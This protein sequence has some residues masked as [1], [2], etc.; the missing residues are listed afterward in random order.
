MLHSHTPTPYL[1][2]ITTSEYMEE[3]LA[4]MSGTA[5]AVKNRN[6]MRSS[7]KS[8][9]PDRDCF[10]LVS[11]TP[12]NPSMFTPARRMIGPRFSLP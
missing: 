3:V 6:A 2:Q 10:S 9:F 11:E 7:I 8:V 12:L 1:L 5:Q 4:D